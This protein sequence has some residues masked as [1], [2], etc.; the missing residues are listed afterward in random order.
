MPVIDADAHVVESD[1]TWDYMDQSDMQFRPTL[2]GSA[3]SG[4]QFWF[5]DGKIRGLARSVLSVKKLEDI[6]QATGRNVVTTQAARDMEDI[7]GRL[8]HMDELEIDVQVLHS[9]I[10]IQQIADRPEVEVAVCRAYNR[11]LADIWRQGKGRLRWSAALPFMAMDEAL[12]ELRTAVENGACGA[13][14]RPIEG[15]R[16][17][18]DPYFFPIYEEASR[19]NVPIVFHI[20]N[21]NPENCDLVSQYNNGGSF[22]KFRLPTVG[23]FHSLLMAGIPDAFPKLRFGFV[24]ASS[25]WVP[26]VVSDL[27]RRFPGSGRKFPD[28]PLREYRMYVTCQTD[29]DLEWVLRYAGEDNLMIGT[30]YGHTD[31]SSEIEAIRHLRENGD[32]NPSAINKMLDDNPRALYNL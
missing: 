13:A 19:L 24:E 3:D 5:I 29:D 15:D 21:A 10:F 23:A 4:R 30:D 14:V 2:M 22:W 18:T 28:N 25:Q 20:G 17:P 27:R 7:E 16:L 31:Q 11:W 12:K 9:T 32:I 8:Q 26:Y 6:S 1:R